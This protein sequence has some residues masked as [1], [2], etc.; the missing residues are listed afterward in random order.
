M[1]FP[2]ATTRSK[3]LSGSSA[4]TGR[5]GSTRDQAPSAGGVEHGPPRRRSRRCH[6]PGGRARWPPG[7]SR[8]RRRA[9]WPGGSP[10]SPATRSASPWR[11]WPSAANRAKRASYSSPRRGTFRTVLARWAQTNRIAPDV[12]G[13]RSAFG[14]EQES[15]MRIGLGLEMNGTIDDDRGEGPGPGVDGSGVTVVVTDLRM[16][17]TH[18][19]GRG[20]SRSAG[21]R[22]GHGGDP[23]PPPS[24]HDAGRT[25][26]HGPSRQRWPAGARD[27]PVTP[28]RGRRGVGLLLREAR[29]LHARVPVGAHAPAPRRAGVVQRGGDPDQHLRA[30][31]RCADASLRPCSSPRWADHASPCRDPGRRD[32]PVDGGA[33]PRWRSTSCPPSP[34][35]HPAQVGPRPRWSSPFRCV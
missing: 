6:S 15:G 20:R 31:R 14:D 33:R 4:A 17:H 8:S 30:S 26:A 13:P 34:P 25:G 7:P 22:P 12:P 35:R 29:P 11:Y 16:G 21:R 5:R 1:T 2:A 27:R 24:P 23:G 10:R 9:P 28:G 3:R 19:S 18:G 32:R